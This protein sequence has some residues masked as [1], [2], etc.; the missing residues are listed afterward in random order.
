MPGAQHARHNLPEAPKPGD[1]DVL[2]TLRRDL[3][4]RSGRLPC[5]IERVVDSQQERSR[6]HRQGDGEHQQTGERLVDHAL[7]CTCRKQHEGEFAALTEHESE[8][9]RG[10]R[11]EAP[12][13]AE[14]IEDGGLERDQPKHD[15]KKQHRLRGQHTEIDRH[16]D[17]DEKHGEQQALERRDV[18]LD[19]MTKLRVGEQCASDER[20]KRC[21]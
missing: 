11:A 19:L 20:A 14:H 18:R 16:A 21:R 10:N 15:G 8:T 13:A 4:L 3:V 9:P 17:C 5:A 2:V 7:Q 1:D 6:S 12:P